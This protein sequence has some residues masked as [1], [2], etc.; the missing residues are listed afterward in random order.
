MVSNDSINFKE[1][2]LKQNH[3]ASEVKWNLCEGI[4]KIMGIGDIIF[5][6]KLKLNIAL[7][8]PEK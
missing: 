6:N 1:L 8:F 7:M 5:M 2:S 3:E 4:G